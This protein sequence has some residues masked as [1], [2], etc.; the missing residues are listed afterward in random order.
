MRDLVTCIIP[1]ERNRY[2][3]YI[4][5]HPLPNVLNNDVAL[6]TPLASFPGSYP[7]AGEEP[8]NPLAPPSPWA[9]KKMCTYLSN[10]CHH[11]LENNQHSWVVGTLV[12]CGSNV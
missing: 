11:C 5:H 1:R 6:A 4:A 10:Q 8:G 7:T 3:I 2:L 9:K 12:K